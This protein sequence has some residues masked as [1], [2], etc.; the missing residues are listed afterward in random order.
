LEGLKREESE[1]ECTFGR[2]EREDSNEGS[3]LI[4]R[5]VPA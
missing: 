4:P 5:R 2:I 3:F 1:M